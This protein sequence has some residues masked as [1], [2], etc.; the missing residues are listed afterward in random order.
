MLK[1]EIINLKSLD[2]SMETSVSVSE[3]LMAYGNC[4]PIGEN[5]CYWSIGQTGYEQLQTSFIHLQMNL[6]WLQT[7]YLISSSEGDVVS[8]GVK[9]LF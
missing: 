4:V 7:L 8:I 2:D 6:E 1:Q 3:L 5:K 9:Y